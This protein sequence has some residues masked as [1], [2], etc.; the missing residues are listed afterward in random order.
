M[1]HGRIKYNKSSAG[2]FNVVASHTHSATLSERT[3]LHDHVLEI[4][5]GFR[6]LNEKGLTLPLNPDTQ[7]FL[8]ARMESF[9]VEPSYGKSVETLADE[10]FED[11]DRALPDLKQ[12]I[13]ERDGVLYDFELTHA[14]VKLPYDGSLDHPSVSM[15]FK[16]EDRPEDLIA[17]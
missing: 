5:L 12:L 13:K 16:G 15:T 11:L 4:K 7:A 2:P 17:A 9:F 14:D 1:T 6:S 10:L 3:E 8:Q